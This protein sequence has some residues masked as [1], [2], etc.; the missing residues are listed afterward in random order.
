MN[1]VI[2][3]GK[4]KYDIEKSKDGRLSIKRFN[5]NSKMWVQINFEKEPTNNAKQIERF[6]AEMLA[7]QVIERFA[8]GSD[9]RWH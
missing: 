4:E 8:V 1:N 9:E 7:N 5:R 2:E 3:F 6:I